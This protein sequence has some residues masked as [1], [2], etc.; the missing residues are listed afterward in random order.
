M[1]K[2]AD[3]LFEKEHMSYR[4]SSGNEETRYSY[5]VKALTDLILWD[6]GVSG[7]LGGLKI[8]RFLFNSRL[9]HKKALFICIS[10]KEEKVRHRF[11]WW[12]YANYCGVVTKNLQRDLIVLWSHIQSGSSVGQSRSLIHLRSWVQV[13]PRLQNNK[14]Q[15]ECESIWRR[16]ANDLLLT[17]YT[18]NKNIKNIFI[19]ILQ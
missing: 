12:Q 17:F 10:D 8:R 6:S 19:N 4:S 9:S 16:F 18:T 15:M 2:K 7:V 3:K 13:P 11:E 5:V 1:M 14:G